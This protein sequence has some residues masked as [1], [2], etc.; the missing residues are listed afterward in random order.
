MLALP[1]GMPDREVRAQ[2]LPPVYSRVHGGENDKTL[3]HVPEDDSGV[4]PPHHERL[5]CQASGWMGGAILVHL[6]P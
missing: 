2:L 3:L 6:L 5:V 4:S 1:G